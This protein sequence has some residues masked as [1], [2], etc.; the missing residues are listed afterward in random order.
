MKKEYKYTITPTASGDLWTVEVLHDGKYI[1]EMREFFNHKYAGKAP[2]RKI[3]Q[4]SR[5]R[6]AEYIKR[7]ESEGYIRLNKF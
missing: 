4:L 1:N 6:A 2:N 3:T 7:L 5:D